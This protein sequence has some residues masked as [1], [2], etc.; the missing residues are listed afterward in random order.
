[1]IRINDPADCCGCTACASIC[2]HKAITMSEDKEGFLYPIVDS[3]LCTRCGLCVSVCPIKNR[4]FSAAVK[5][6]QIA[7]KAIRIKNN[8]LLERSSS[9]GAFI[10]IASYIINKGGVVCGAKYTDDSVVIH[11]FAYTLEDIYLNYF[12][13]Y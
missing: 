11:S 3:N 5:P 4:G 8:S 6:N 9:G 7:Y 1:M 12:I 2:N 10:A 13:V